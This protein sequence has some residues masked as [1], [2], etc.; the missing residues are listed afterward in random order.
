MGLTM[1]EKTLAAATDESVVRPGDVIFPNIDFITATDVTLPAA[2]QVLEHVG[3]HKIAGADKVSIS[4]D[5]YLLS[6]FQE[7][8]QLA[9]QSKRFAVKHGIHHT[10]K[11]GRGGVAHISNILEGLIVPG[12]LVIAGE[13]HGCAVG[14]IGALGF[15][16]GATDLAV[17]LSLGQLWITVPETVRVT[18]TGSM[19]QFITGK[20]LGLLLQREVPADA[21]L[22][23][24]VEITGEPVSNL[25]G[26]DRLVLADLAAEAGA[27]TCMIPPNE[28][29]LQYLEDRSQKE[30]HYYFDDEDAEYAAEFEISLDNAESMLQ[31]INKAE[32]IFAASALDDKQQV[33]TVVIGGCSGGQMEDF[34]LAAQVMKY[35]QVH[36]NVRLI[37]IPATDV[38]FQQMV[39]QGLA[40]IFAELGASIWPPT[41]IFCADS[42]VSMLSNNENALITGKGAPGITRANVF[43]GSVPVAAA[44]AVNGYITDPRTFV[45]EPESSMI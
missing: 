12:D 10:F 42:P 14:G 34:T 39:N 25:P 44:T 37:I 13:S 17:A 19:D 28:V 1:I 24:A 9:D 40:S 30:A 20:D 16:V 11:T 8:L 29:I 35:R 38:T 21:I 15:R 4:V 5:N 2:S 23:R 7:L 41:C 36:E 22:N 18:F 45:D 3:L 26:P 27:V 32:R 43:T 31:D 33:D 6:N